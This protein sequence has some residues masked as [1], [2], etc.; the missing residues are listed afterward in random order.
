M[1]TQHGDELHGAIETS[2]V[3]I[4]AIKIDIEPSRAK[5]NVIGLVVGS[6]CFEDRATWQPF[7]LLPGSCGTP[8]QAL[9]LA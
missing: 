5:L 3:A 9:E 4:P 6:T 7:L 2:F 1:I 8:S